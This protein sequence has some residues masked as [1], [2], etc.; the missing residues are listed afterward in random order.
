LVAAKAYDRGMS[1]QQIKVGDR[2]RAQGNPGL[3]VRIHTL[4]NGSTLYHV[5]ST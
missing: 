2:V 1:V 5:R 4:S 3:V